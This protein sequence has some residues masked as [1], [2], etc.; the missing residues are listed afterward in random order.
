M[1]LV[2]LDGSP[3]ERVPSVRQAVQCP[4]AGF[5]LRDG[6]IASF[7]CMEDAAAIEDRVRG[8]VGIGI[9]LGDMR[10][11]VLQLSVE[12]SQDLRPAWRGND[13]SGR[14]AMKEPVASSQP[15]SPMDCP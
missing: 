6:D 13:L 7:D 5:S 4:I 8:F 1:P 2:I 15:M 11:E 12:L 10:F 9:A 14:K 3:E